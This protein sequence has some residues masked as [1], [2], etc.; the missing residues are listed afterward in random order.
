MIQINNI[1]PAFT[2]STLSVSY[3]GNIATNTTIYI[4]FYYAWGGQAKVGDPIIATYSNN[5]I[6]CQEVSS[7]LGYGQYYK[8]V[9]LAQQQ[10]SDTKTVFSNYATIKYIDIDIPTVVLSCDKNNYN[11]QATFS[12]T[13]NNLEYMKTVRYILT[14][15]TNDI[16]LEDSGDILYNYTNQTLEN[17]TYIY[18][19][20]TYCP[21]MAT[22]YE[23]TVEYVTING[24]AGTVTDTLEIKFQ[25]AENI[26][27]DILSCLYN[28]EDAKIDVHTTLAGSLF[29]RV[30]FY[31][32]KV[33]DVAAGDVI[34]DI[35][36]INNINNSH[37]YYLITNEQ[38]DLTQDIKVLGT[39]YVAEYNSPTIYFEHIYLSDQNKQLCI[40]FNPKIS[41]FKETVLENKVETI[42]GTYP[43]IFRNGDVRYHEMNLGGLISVL[44][45]NNHLF[46]EANMFNNNSSHMR[47]DTPNTNSITFFD[48]SA[49]YINENNFKLKVIHWLNNGQPKV[50]RTPNEGNYIVQL[51]NVVCTPEEKL[52]RML[53][54]F[55]CTAVEI[56]QYS[57]ENLLKYN[58]LTLKP[59]GEE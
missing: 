3:T 58:L 25:E 52:G 9:V 18:K 23:V 14:E 39:I 6:T 50:L 41:S 22:E 57:I 34:Q 19:F 26:D 13:P 46:Q 35:S 15:S 36:V 40:K 47:V 43:K 48:N 17:Q 21:T 20:S 10:G 33:C 2:G 8:I 11:L 12:Y 31:G 5:I 1:Q 59:I 24:F 51:M 32:V 28:A 54:S 4:Q 29:K 27:N 42:G 38:Q 16:I 55:S 37:K 56:E 53:Y 45:D 44:S 49:Q 30:G 7:E